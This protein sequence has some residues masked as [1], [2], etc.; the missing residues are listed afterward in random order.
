MT[1]KIHIKASP[2]PKAQAALEEL[3]AL[4]PPVPIEDAEVVVALGGDGFML[5]QLHACIQHKK[6]VY[7]MNRGSTGFLL[8]H[9]RPD[10]LLERLAQAIEVELHPLRMEAKTLDGGI[11]TGLGINEVSLL[12][13][14]RQAAKIRVTVNGVL[15]LEE[16]MGDGLLVATPEGSSAY[17]VSANGPILPLKSQLLALTPINPFR[18]RRWKGAL[19]PQMSVLEFEVLSP[20]LRRVSATADFTEIRDVRSVKVWEDETVTLRLLFDPETNLE[21]R[22]LAEQ[23]QS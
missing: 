3:T 12:R 22:I 11:H 2:T 14:T 13:E 1:L 19:L 9:Y 20:D 6:P 8:N 16:L 17:N 7:G 21:E 23:F 15:R 18:P 5:E 4:Y 10:H